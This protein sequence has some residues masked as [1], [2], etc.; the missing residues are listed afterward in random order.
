MTALDEEA[1]K[2]RFADDTMLLP[3]MKL[4]FDVF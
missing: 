3:D 4:L 1:V 2:K